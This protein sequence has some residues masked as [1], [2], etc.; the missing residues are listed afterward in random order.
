MI[1]DVWYDRWHPWTRVTRGGT[2]D[3]S[4]EDLP[5]EKDAR[6][7]TLRRPTELCWF[8]N[9]RKELRRIRMKAFMVRIRPFDTLSRTLGCSHQ[10]V[11]IFTLRSRGGRFFAGSWTKI[12][13]LAKVKYVRI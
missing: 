9:I 13:A 2:A 11:R 1:G 7:G 5:S 12:F 8:R 10:I 4:V 6:E 3:P